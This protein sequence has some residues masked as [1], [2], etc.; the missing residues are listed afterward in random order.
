[1]NRQFAQRLAIQL[2]IR[3]IQAMNK[4]RIRNPAHFSSGLDSDDPQPAEITLTRPAI[5][6]RKASITN[7]RFFD[8]SQQILSAAVAS[9]GFAEQSLMGST[10]SDAVTDSHSSSSSTYAALDSMLSE[11]QRQSETILVSGPQRFAD[12]QGIG[13]DQNRV[14]SVVSLAIA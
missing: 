7:D 1:M 14:I 13:P 8:R 5:T 2:Q 6:V 9:L 12:H 10:T 4:S 3:Q 11:S